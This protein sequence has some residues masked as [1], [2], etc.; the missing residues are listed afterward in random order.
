MRTWW[1]GPGTKRIGGGVRSGGHT[2]R[3]DDQ[4]GGSSSSG[5]DT[6]RRRVSADVGMCALT[7]V[8]GEVMWAER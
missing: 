6:R 1:T 7:R 8:G 4:G 2:G 5:G 3:S